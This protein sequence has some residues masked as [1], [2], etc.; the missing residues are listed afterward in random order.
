MTDHIITI[1]GNPHRVSERVAAMVRLVAE[2]A[3]EVDRHPV[4][5]LTVSWSN[6][7]L[8]VELSKSRPT[9]HLTG[10]NKVT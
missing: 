6:M 3:S 7:K 9:T 4:G 10:L 8:W 1:D 2:D 5:R